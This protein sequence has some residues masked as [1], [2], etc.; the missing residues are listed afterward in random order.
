MPRW[1]DAR[2]PVAF[3]ALADAR[4]DDAV[5]T[6][7]AAAGHPAACA[8]CTARTPA[9]EALGRLFLQRARGEVGFFRR[10]LVDADAQGQEAVREA[11][12]AD[13][14]VAARFRFEPPS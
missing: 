14:I 10:V 3:S 6:G 4:P 2:V 9:A 1:I 11:L 5:L 12:R 8:C 7:I 13:P